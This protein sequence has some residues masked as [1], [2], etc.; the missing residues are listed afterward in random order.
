MGKLWIWEFPAR[1]WSWFEKYNIEPETVAPELASV[2]NFYDQLIS[3]AENDLSQLRYDLSMVLAIEAR[4]RQWAKMDPDVLKALRTLKS[5][6]KC[7]HLKGA[8]HVGIGPSGSIDF[9]VSKFIF[10]TGLG[11][12]RCNGCGK[13]WFKGDPGWELAVMMTKNS[14]NRAASS[15]QV[16]MHKTEEAVKS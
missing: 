5:E 15:E 11:R 16:V 8:G 6:D 10:P 4:N 3:K 9:N 1:V 14:T 2:I 12:I 13:K 7:S